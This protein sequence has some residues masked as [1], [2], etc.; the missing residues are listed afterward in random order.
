VKRGRLNSQPLIVG[1]KV[2]RVLE[3][4]LHVVVTAAR[5]DFSKA[6]NSAGRRGRPGGCNF[7]ALT[8]S[9]CLTAKLWLCPW[10]SVVEPLLQSMQF[11]VATVDL[12][13][14][15]QQDRRLPPGRGAR[16][17]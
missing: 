13:T 8:V 1:D 11:S 4:R 12:V 17:P 16:V 3:E 15:L 6:G 14:H 5:R 7:A 9:P 10:W 2:A